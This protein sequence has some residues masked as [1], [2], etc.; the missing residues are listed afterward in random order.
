MIL[1]RSTFSTFSLLPEHRPSLFLNDN[2]ASKTATPN[3]I[4]LTMNN[5]TKRDPIVALSRETF[6]Q[7]L[8][9]LEPQS[10]QASSAVSKAWTIA[11]SKNQSTE[12]QAIQDSHQ[13]LA[14][15]ETS[16]LSLDLLSFFHDLPPE[17]QD[18]QSKVIE[19]IGSSFNPS[20]NIL[21]E[22][23][24]TLEPTNLLGDKEPSNS[25]SFW[26]SHFQTTLD[27]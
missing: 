10:L 9:F 2:V 8:T 22:I 20:K 17:G 5:G 11:E 26:S 4:L 7:V 12:E 21:N 25:F 24:F 23:S 13:F 19:K 27:S 18:W 16:N 6:S 1:S 14:L 15:P 3:S